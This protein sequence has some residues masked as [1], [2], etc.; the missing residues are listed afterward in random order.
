MIK[1]AKYVNYHK[2]LFCLFSLPKRTLY[3][4]F[5][6]PWWKK[7]KSKSALDLCVL[8]ALQF[9]LWVF[10]VY[11]KCNLLQDHQYVCMYVC[12]FV[13]LARRRE[14]EASRSPHSPGSEGTGCRHS[15]A[16]TLGRN[17]L[18]RPGGSPETGCT[19]PP[20]YPCLLLG[21][22][23]PLRS[24]KQ[25]TVSIVMTGDSIKAILMLFLKG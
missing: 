19:C 14:M 25:M 11:M 23:L 1:T 2:G 24:T 9:P 5:S 3:C 13:Y 21:V 18:R 17:L 20:T 16:E 8:D 7:Y 4:M 22:Y 15:S 10:H 12:V 6:K